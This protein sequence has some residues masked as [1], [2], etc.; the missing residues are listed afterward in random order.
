MK[1]NKKELG[2][3]QSLKMF[4]APAGEHIFNKALKKVL[5]ILWHNAVFVRIGIITSA[6]I[7]P[8]KY[9]EVILLQR[10]GSANLARRIFIF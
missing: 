7:F 8:L 1:N 6:L 10:Y 3:L 2:K 5:I 4:T 9:F